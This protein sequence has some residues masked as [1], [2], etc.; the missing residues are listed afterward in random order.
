MAFLLGMSVEVIEPKV[1]LIKTIQNAAG[2]DISGQTVGLGSELFYNVRFQ[3]VGTDNA[4]NT[5]I[6]DILPKNVD[7]LPNDLI[8][9]LE[10]EHTRAQILSDYEPP[11]AANLF[12]GKLIFNIP[13]ALVEENDGYFDIKIKVQVVSDCSQ[14]R[15]VC[16]NLISNQ[17]FANYESDRGG[18]LPINNEESFAGL[19]DCNFGIVGTSNFLVDTS[20][21]VYERTEV[22]CGNTT[23]LIAGAG[24]SAYEWRDSSNTIIG[25]SR[26]VTVTSTGTY[27]VRTTAPVG[28]IDTVETVHVVGYN[29]EPNPLVPFADQMLVCANNSL[30]LAEMYLCGVGSTRAINL[31]FDPAS[32]TTVEWYK[33]DEASCNDETGAGCPNVDT[34]CDWGAPLSTNFSLNVADAGEY[35]LDVEYDG[36]CP[37]SYYFNVFKATLNPDIVELDIFCGSNGSITV[38]NIPSNY[39]YSL[40]GPGGYNA[41]F[42]N[43]NVFNNLTTAGDYDLTIRLNN[44]TAASCVY[45]FPSI[46]IQE[47]DIDFVVTTSDMECSDS[48]ASINA[49]VNNVIGDYTY[50]LTHS[51]VGVVATEGPTA[52]SSHLFDG[53]IDGGSYTV[54]VTTAQCTASETV[55]INKPDP[56]NLAA[57]KLKDISCENGSSDGIIRLTATGGTVDTVSGNNY[58]MAVWTSQG[59][60]L[61]TQPSDVPFSALLTPSTNPY[62]Y[63]I[64]VGNEG[65][66]RFIVFDDNGCYSISAPITVI[67]EAPL[68]FTHT[69]V[70][71]SCNGQND[72]TTNVQVVDDLGY[73]IQ[74]SIDNTNWFA[75][76]YFDSLTPGTHTVYIRATKTS[77]QCNYEVIDIE[78]TELGVLGGN[79]DVSQVYTCAQ[80]GEITVE[81]V[82]GGTAPY[83][84][85]LS[86]GTITSA[87]HTTN[88]VSFDHTFTGLEDGTYTVTISDAKSCTITTAAVTIAPLPTTPTLTSA[89]TYSCDGRGVITVGPLDATYV[90]TLNST[91]TAIV[92]TGNN[93]FT[94]VPVGTYTVTVNYGSDCSLDTTNISV[95]DNQ[96]FTAQV[97]DITNPTCIGNTNGAIEITAFFPSVVPTSFEYST[98]GGTSW[99]PAATNPFSVPNLADGT[100]AILV[101]PDNTSPAACNVSLSQDLSDPSPIA[102]VATVTKGI[103]CNADAN[104]DGATITITPTTSGGNGGPY[105]YELFAD[106]AGVPGA[107]VQTGAP[108]TDIDTVGNYWVIASDASSCTSAPVLVNVPDKVVVAFDLDETTCY[109]GAADAT[110][111]VTNLTGNGV[112]YTYSL[113]DGTTT[114]TQN[115]NMFTNLTDGSYTVT[116]TDG[117]GC[118][119]TDTVTINPQLTAGVVTTNETCND[120]TITITPS[121]GT[122]VYQYAVLAGGSA[123]PVLTAFS[124]TAPTAITAGTW[125]VYVRDQNAGANSCVFT[126]TVTVTRITDP[127][128]D[129]TPTQPDCSG[130]QGSALVV[131]SDGTADY[132]TTITLQGAPGTVQTSGSGAGTNIT[133][134]NLVEGTYDIVTTDANNCSIIFPSTITI[135]APNTLAGETRLSQVYTCAQQGEITVENVVGGTAP[136]TYTLSDGTITS[137]P[138]TTNT[139]SFDHTFTGLEDGTYTVTISDAKSCTITTAAVTIAP[140]PT[141]PTLTS[142]VTYSCDG[143]GVITVGPLD[144]TYV[145]T[146]NSTPTAI[147][148]TGNNIFTDV[149]VGTYTVTVN[150]GSDCSLDTTNISVL[151]NQEFT[152]QV[153]DITNPTCIGNT[154][155]AIEITAF[156]PSV[157][158]T[159]FE[160]STDGGTSWSPAA[161]NPF[162]V[163][164]L[165]DGTHTILVRPDN[166]S[167][168]A[169]NVSL[170]QDLSDP[171]PIAVVATVT[172]DIDC[173]ADAN[174]D[175]A[176]ITITP[177]TSGGNGGPYT[178]ELFA[179]NAGVPGASVQTGAPFTDIDTVGNYWVIASDASSCT[180]AP[181][182]VNVPD[183][184][185]VAFDL[186]ETTCYS[187]AAD[188][189]ITV[190]NLTG[191]GVPYTYSLNDG[192]TTTTQ[193]TNMFTNLTDG[194]YTVTVT[195]GFGC[196]E[197]DTV[198]INPQLTAGVVTTNETCNDGTITITPSGGTGVYQYAVLAGG[199]AAPVLTAFSTTAPTAITAG[200]WDVYVRDQNAGANSCVFTT[201]VT[202]TRITDPT[203][204]VTPTQPDCSGGQGSALVVISDGTADYTTTITLQGA[205]GTVQTS[206]PGAGTNITFTNLAAGTYD[207]VT[208]DGNTCAT[209]A[210]T[211]TI[212][213]PGVLGGNLDVS[214][215]YT[216]AQQGE[217]TVENVVGGTAPYTYTLSDGTI[218]SAPH[219]TNTVSFDHTFTGLEDG[220]YTV[221]ISDAKSCTITTAAVTIAPLPTTPTLTSA[222][223]YSC[224]GRGVITVGP[225]DATYVY[226]LNSTPTAIVQTGNNIFTDVPVGT[227]TVTVNYGSDCSLDTTNISVLDNQEFTAQVTDITNPTCIGNTNGAIEITAFFPSVVPTSF[228]YSTDGGT[229]WSPAATNPFSVPNLADG[230]HTILVRPDNTSPAACNVSLSQDLSDPSPIAV[231]ATVTKDIDCNADANLDGATITITPTTSGGNGESYTY[232]L[233]ADNAGVPGASVQTGAPFTDIDTVGNYW[234]IASDASSCTSAPVLVNV[235][236]K[237]VVAFDLDETTCYSGAADATI[238]VTN[239]TGNGVPYTYSLNDGTTTTTQNTNMFT[240][241]TDGSY[242][243]TVTDGFGCSETDTVTINPQLTAGVVTTNETC[244][245]GTIT[246]TPSGGT[247]VYQ[248]AVLAGGSA[249]PVLTAF[250]T[251]APTAITAGTW[252]VY[253]RDQNAGA[254]SCVFTTT[255]TVTRI[256]DPTIDV[257]P[258]QPDCSG[259]QGSALVVISDGTADYTTTITLQGAPGT[260]Q[261]SGPGAGTNIT[262]T[263]LAAGTYDVVT[264]DGNT[265][266]TAASTITITAP[267][268][269]G[270]NLDVSQVYTCAQQ[271]EITVENVVGGTAPYTY[272]LSDGTITSAPHTTNTVS[273]DHTFTGLED[274]TYTVTIS[275]AKSCT[276]TTAAVTIAP[277][278]TTPTLTSAVTYSCDGRG[279]ITVGP[280]DATY[281]YTLNSTPTAIVQT[282][283]NIFTDVPVGTYTVT[284]NYGSDC[285]LDTTNISVLD[286][287]EFTAQVTDITN[288]TCIGNTNGAIEITA[289]FP[290]VVPTSFEYSTDGGTSWSPAATN[291]FSVPNLADGTHTI[292]VRPDNTSPAACNVSLS[293][294]LSDPSPIAVVA[295]V[296]KDIDCNAD[297]NLDGATIT[298]TPTTSGGNGESYT[299]ELFADNAGVPGASVQ[300][301]AP[302]TDIDTVGNYW[303]IASDASSCTSAPVLVNVP[304][305]ETFT[306]TVTPQCYTSG[307][308]VVDVSITSSGAG[309]V[310]YEYSLDGTNWVANTPATATSF[311]I[312]SAALS[313]S[314]AHTVY[315][316]NSYHCVVSNAVTINPVITANATPTNAS[317]TP[318]GAPTGEILVTPTGGSGTGYVFSVV[319]SGAAA[320]APGTFAATNPITGLT[321]NTYDVYVRDDAGC[322][323]IVQDVVIAQIIPIA[324][325]ATAN[326]PTCNGDTGSVDGVVTANT[327]QAPYT[328]TLANSGGIIGAETLTNYTANTFSFN[329]LPAETYT[330]EITDALGCI[331]TVTPLTLANPPAIVMDI[332]GV[333]PPGCAINPSLTGFDFINIDPTNYLPN[334]LEYSIDNGTTWTVFTTGQ[335]RNLNSGDIVQPTLRTVDGSGTPLCLVA[336]G[337][338]EVLYNVTGLIV[339]PVANPGNCSVGFSVTVE[340]LNS[341]GPFQF[342]IGSPSGWVEIRCS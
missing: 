317:C 203:I 190:T 104:L 205:P 148:Q 322:E 134:N 224:D 166:T 236:D 260:V 295:T 163:P 227:Y 130:G 91:P 48:T 185:V 221:T 1:Q 162:S 14:L 161:T 188:A 173:N 55:V 216:C 126:T 146:L 27:T 99:S 105:T 155:G 154:N 264:S 83:T 35:R 172:K 219:T 31:P 275:D 156:F 106:N 102:V 218:T 231:V 285:S 100:H 157:V 192:T 59:T 32:A 229:S 324:I 332:S 62:T 152:A 34:G 79:L 78:I 263:N 168:A 310:T 125:D 37:K 200:T 167:P 194:S 342:A 2:D 288:P 57:L 312:S 232:E 42:Q 41:P 225:L 269:L 230:T 220:T 68:T 182:L 294:D 186:D 258:T 339:D 141:T 291:P 177:T 199:S 30:D 237:V 313:T 178:Y 197:T 289:F 80:Q 305:K 81:N 95:L 137:A 58:N 234:V 217:I 235:P 228:E 333:L 61:Y 9:P 316:R 329:N 307:N 195:D 38:N 66:Y 244:N 233:F 12:R 318:A 283:N 180:S 302:F 153:T 131:I 254:N 214:Q 28:C 165:A 212:T 311:S 132:T 257:T 256:T 223:T 23:D 319:T 145:Y 208:S 67:R 113:N 73:A 323:Y 3:N 286:N 215:V 271:G 140:L 300:T 116:V 299:Y 326:E 251:T 136:Y 4:K 25:T 90:Y 21:C 334:I 122:G 120:G 280:L 94:D 336:Y 139:V 277:L 47:S 202:V 109:S 16:S 77:Y 247:G 331:S 243:V 86:D 189:T 96:E 20:G 92:Q 309:S 341:A 8:L 121:G 171:S 160:Y 54:T 268:V 149:P 252:D 19:N 211:I 308:G 164:N 284:V 250:S 108:F 306:F 93:I 88:T 22:I 15:D 118:S 337:D 124:T 76:G 169:C 198:T 51:T 184:V 209:A 249:A 115:T 340:A 110:I 297:A 262:F 75:T 321:A 45:S 144:A 328:I 248:Y 24:F 179:D 127:T 338:Y 46:N 13:D 84:Y 196:S 174:L 135:T 36:Q 210:S 138:H 298:I 107:S 296:T 303:V 325:T 11:T 44:S 187:G 151:D 273:F 82:V 320:P 123:A 242:T 176:T 293:Q 335:V 103:D 170:S 43:N 63:N 253:V 330:V 69:D 147:V 52:N 207:V 255:V 315:I 150:Y 29:S 193:N 276:I 60:D 191:N 72:G 175:G 290:S 119:E 314:I 142:A 270:G 111:T 53:L 5:R 204:D 50:T 97:T 222:V 226:T 70:N 201:T 287:Q 259:G 266:A 265:C 7:F 282:G 26:T 181:V 261:T 240:N 74:Y 87:P 33:L 327:G 71:V 301:G 292:L 6:I 10:L 159:S 112:P 274:G 158:P 245:D 117:F 56:I 129:V 133:F 143:R 304:D 18:A 238:T 239:L 89:V 17:A 241:L 114:T 272:T 85:T 246:I 101:R 65:E 128:I 98:D 40:S 49:Q 183:K 64:P 267:G 213:A 278:P 39:Q 281:V 279:V 206:G